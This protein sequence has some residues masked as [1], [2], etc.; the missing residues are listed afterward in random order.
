MAPALAA[1]VSPVALVT[2]A[3][4]G[5]GAA[6]VDHLVL[7][8]WHVVAIDICADDPNRL[9]AR[10]PADLAALAARHG[11]SSPSR[12]TSEARPTWTARCTR[13]AEHFGSV[14]AA[15]AAAGVIHGGSALG[16]LGPRV[17]DP[18]R[19]QRDRSPPAGHRR[20]AGML[21]AP[22]PRHGRFVAVASTAGLLGL[23]LLSAYTASKHAVIGLVKALAADLAGTGVTANAICPG[24]TR[25]PILD[26]SAAVYGLS[27]PEEFAT[28]S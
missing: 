23:R 21:A 19:R 17:A 22:A 25:T 12:P 14:D 3:A 15:V 26:A 28:N 7:D 5:I 4:R 6:T 10:V 13:C 18:V 8:G 24:S 1:V 20:H 9:P 27:S 2:G 11:G 16:E